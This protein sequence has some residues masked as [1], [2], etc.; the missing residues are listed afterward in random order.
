MPP[1]LCQTYPTVEASGLWREREFGKI[2]KMLRDRRFELMGSWICMDI[3]LYIIHI[4]VYILGDGNLNILNQ[5]LP[6][7][8]QLR[9]SN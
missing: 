9:I 1:A 8:Q 6:A 7:N 2:R 4:Y 3:Y 5:Q